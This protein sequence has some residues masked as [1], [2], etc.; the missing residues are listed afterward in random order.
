MI[1]N[2]YIKCQVCGSVTRVRLQIG[3]LS[4]HPI[5]ITCGKCHTSLLGVVYIGQDNLSLRY[6]F[7]NADIINEMVVSDFIVE[8]S[9][10]FPVKKQRRENVDDMIDTSPYIRNIHKIYGNDSYEKFRESISQL[11]AVA[12]KWKTYKRILNLFE[13]KS[14]FLVQEIKKEFKGTFF[15]CDNEYEILRS[16][17]NIEVLNFYTPLKSEILNTSQFGDEVLKLNPIQMKVLIGFLNSHKGYNLEEVQSKIYSLLDKFVNV[18]PS[19]IPAISL[20]YIGEDTFDF[21]NEGSTTSTFDT[22][23]QFY[24]DIY[25]TLG[26][27][28]II[29]VALNNIKYRNNINISATVNSKV[30]TLEEYINLTKAN[31]YHFCLNNEIFTGFLGVK[32]NVKLRNAIGHNDIEYDTASQLI[33]YF[34]DPKNRVKKEIE[35]LLEFESEAVHMF[36]GILVVSVA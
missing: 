19:L 20:Q 1:H 21:K 29:P 3:Y 30:Y 28:M 10:E 22:V 36:Q 33:T 32:I 12:F 14:E 23:K 35:Y 8:C 24:L 6:E 15:T 18:F 26:N 16:V 13:N 34:P 7:D 25:E 2:S 4:Q 27:L 5:V 17:H 9:G 11:H 31:R